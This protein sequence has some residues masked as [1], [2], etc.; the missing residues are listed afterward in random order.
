M[1]SIR[2]NRTVKGTVF[3][4]DSLLLRNVT[5]LYAHF[6]ELS[7]VL[8]TVSD[9]FIIFALDLFLNEAAENSIPRKEIYL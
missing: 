6:K 5:Y 9:K 7:W 8:N 2:K 1:N 3:D 4:L